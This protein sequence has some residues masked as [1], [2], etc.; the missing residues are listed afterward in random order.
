[1][2]WQQW[3][4]N[5]VQ[6]KISVGQIIEMIWF[7]IINLIKWRKNINRNKKAFAIWLLCVLT[8]P[9]FTRKYLKFGNLNFLALKIQLHSHIVRFYYEYGGRILFSYKFAYL[10]AEF[11]YICSTLNPFIDLLLSLSFRIW[12]FKQKQWL[13]IT[14]WLI[15]EKERE[16]KREWAM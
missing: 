4:T 16:T 3:N 12:W 14:D 6:S 15:T 1:M 10:V 11:A 5:I 2:R 13:I 9:I 8:I 7:I